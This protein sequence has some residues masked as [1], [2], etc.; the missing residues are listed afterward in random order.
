[1]NISSTITY[2]PTIN[3]IQC[4]EQ[5]VGWEDCSDIAFGDIISSVRVN[6]TDS[7]YYVANASF[8]LNNVP[9]DIKK[10]FL[11]IVNENVKISTIDI[12][13]KIKLF[14]NA[15]AFSYRSLGYPIVAVAIYGT[16]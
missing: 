8:R 13:G 7:D 16:S 3:Q 10:K 14:I 12:V 4:E 11:E 2:P 9:D 6:C 15:T 1:M 5:G